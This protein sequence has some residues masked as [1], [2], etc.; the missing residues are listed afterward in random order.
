MSR[1]GRS[2]SALRRCGITLD[3]IALVPASLLPY[4]A[5]YQALANQLPA[6]E[7]LIVLPRCPG[8]ERA[9]LERSGQLLV[10]KGRRVTLISA[11]RIFQTGRCVE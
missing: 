4:K 11:T 8:R 3:N 1:V 7:I 2:P 6:G 9:I 5:R 10:A